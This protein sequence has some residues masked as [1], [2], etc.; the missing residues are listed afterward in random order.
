MIDLSHGFNLLMTFLFPVI[1]AFTLIATK[2]S[3]GELRRVAEQQFYACLVVVTMVTLHT[4]TTCN[5]AWLV[6]TL[7]LA[8]M[9]V[10][11]LVVPSHEPRRHASA[12][13]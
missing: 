5:S 2:L 7:T 3:R 11:A 1:G 9:V 10:G 8:T 4:V 12:H 6:H 13:A